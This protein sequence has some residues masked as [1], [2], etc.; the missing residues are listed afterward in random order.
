[1][2]ISNRLTKLFP[3]FKIKQ[4]PTA[5]TQIEFLEQELDIIEDMP[6][7]IEYYTDTILNKELNPNNVMNSHVLWCFG[8]L[9]TVDPNKPVK[10]TPGHVSLPD[11]D[12][13]I[14]AFFR[15]E[16]IDYTRS[17]Y[18]NEC[19]AKIATFSRMDG[20][21]AIKEVFRILNPVFNSHEL[22]NLITSHMID[23]SKI[24]DELQDLKEENPKYNTVNYN[25]DNVQIIRDEYYKEYKH[26]FDIA[27]KMASTIKSMGK[28][29]AGIVICNQPLDTIFPVIKNDDGMVLAL[30]MEFAEYAGAVKYD[31]LGVLA[32]DKIGA[33]VD[34]INKNLKEPVIHDFEAADIENSELF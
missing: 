26:E 14:A 2:D 1:M 25:I 4:K 17:K 12:V 32:Y 29:A 27:I 9:N 7:G 5:S 22:A 6:N 20:K 13:D 16:L 10:F 15:K 11:I 34:M 30:E 21:G 28:H 31:F 18:G 8:K 24:S 23:A 19:V 33:I 3:K